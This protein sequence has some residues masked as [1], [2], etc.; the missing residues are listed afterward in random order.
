MTI[1]PNTLVVFLLTSGYVT[2][3]AQS[4]VIRDFGQAYNL[5]EK[6]TT[7]TQIVRVD[8][9][10]PGDR[11][12]CNLEKIDPPGGPFDVWLEGSSMYSV[13]YVGANNGGGLSYK[14]VK[15]YMLTIRCDNSA[16]NQ[17]DYKALEVDILPN[18]APVITNTKYPHDVIALVARDFSVP[19]TD[20]YTVKA[21]DVDGD[22]LTCSL[23][24]RPLVNYFTIVKSA[25]SSGSSTD[26]IVKTA[27]D[28][29]SA[30][31]PMVT[32]KVSVS[33]WATTTNIFDIDVNSELN[34]RPQILNLPTTVTI[35]ETTASGFTI[36]TLTVH[37]PDVFVP[38][39]VPTCTVEPG[40]EQYKFTFETGSHKIKLSNLPNGAPPL[41]Y[42][43]TI[44]YTITCTVTDGFLESE[45]EVL[46]VK[47]TNVNEPPVFD[48]VAYYCDL[49]ESEAG[50]SSCDLNA[51]IT[52][53]EGDLIPSVGFLNG[54]NSNR[55]RYDRSTS[56]ITFNVNYDV[57]QNAMPDNVVLQL[58]ASDVYG[59]SKTAPVY[60]KV[61]DVNDNT[62]N[63]GSTS[64]HHFNA[65]QGTLLGSL[66]NFRAT[67]EDRTSPNNLV[68]YDV[69][70]ALPADSTNYIAAFGDGSLAYI[71]TIPEVNH[72]RTYTLI[73]RCKDGGSPQRTAEGTVVLTYQTTTTTSTTT[74]TTPTPTTTPVTT[75]STRAP[76]HNPFDYDAFVAVFAL[77]MLGL[78]GGLL[79]GAYFLWRFCAAAEGSSFGN[80]FCCTK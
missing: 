7:K 80:N 39:M 1:K 41:D 3:A 19:G 21:S 5:H 10:V 12:I 24:T 14:R 62:C 28:L 70:Q 42:E 16:R 49:D 77:L 33:D 63:F 32:L 57:D 6:T 73:V 52:D 76:S 30:S 60:I 51:V 55:F 66:G 13:Y 58:Q 47:V 4:P 45:N 8:C 11:C 79:A 64:T 65:D 9:Y 74:T 29:R 20:V 38:Q 75:T 37:D 22:V 34:T 35:P 59:A 72:G 56:S 53:P 26:C 43:T 36:A 54:N 69:I 2:C 48:E 61:H 44:L 71:G 78:A 50:G 17:S 46:T 40:S 31:E 67:D 25:A 23:T 15:S 27:V 68:T 18:A